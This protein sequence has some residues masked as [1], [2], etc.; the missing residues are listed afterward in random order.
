MPVISTDMHSHC[1]GDGLDLDF[2]MK[3]EFRIRL[4]VFH[5][6]VKVRTFATQ[7]DIKVTA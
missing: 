7:V 1:G 6:M 2:S 4:Q 3:L 5:R